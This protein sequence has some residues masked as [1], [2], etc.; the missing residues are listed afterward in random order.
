L[1]VIWT[2]ASKDIVDAIKSKTTLSIIFGVMLTTLSG[3]ALPLLLKIKDVP[4]AAVYDAGDARLVD[5][6]RRRED[7]RVYT[8]RSQAEMESLLTERTEAVLGLVLPADFDTTLANGQKVTLQGYAAHWVKVE[9]IA[10]LQILFEREI[11]AMT[12]QTIQIDTTTP[13][14][15]PT[16]DAGGQLVMMTMSLVIA[17]VLICITLVPYLIIDEKETHTIDALLVSPASVGQVVAGKA[18]AGAVYGLLAGG[19]AVIF[20]RIVVVHGWVAIL[21]VVCG[22][23]FAVAIGLILG[24]IF[25]NPQSMGV[26][27]G[28][29]T[30]ALLVPVFTEMMT[31]NETWPA[32]VRALLPQM[33]T[34]LLSSLF[35][36]SF[37]ETVSSPEIFGHLG[38]VLLWSLPLYAFVVWRVRRMDR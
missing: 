29:V 26:W 18:I 4:T 10:K 16:S 15:Y 3:Q 20:G 38:M 7:L 19:L 12:N 21:T 28:V 23:V 32:I 8:V 31:M 25:D 6:L 33:P 35:R 13:R 5:V 37:T 30:M 22:T 27:M 34:A 14:L 9:D 17:T 2:I 1:R 11:S 24:S 36:L